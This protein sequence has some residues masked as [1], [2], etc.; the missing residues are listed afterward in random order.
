MRAFVFTDRALE[1]HAGRFV[2]LSI[3]AE[4]E[5]NAG[6]LEKYP[7]VGFPTFLVID[8]DKETA[9]FRQ[10]GGFSA[11]DFPKVLDDGERGVD[12]TRPRGGVVPRRAVVVRPERGVRPGRQGRA[13]GDAEL[14]LRDGCLVGPRL[15]AVARGRR[16]EGR[17]AA[18]R[19]GRA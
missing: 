10:L 3:D 9:A 16:E 18:V 13:A 12:G 1:R 14:S 2:W 6:F 4:K 5:K 19:D 15:R 11:K 17:G 7:I 8:P